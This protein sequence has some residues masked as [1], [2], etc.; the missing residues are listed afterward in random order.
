MLL[1]EQEQ[2]EFARVLE[3]QAMQDGT[4]WLIEGI[5]ETL[6]GKEVVKALMERR[7]VYSI[8]KN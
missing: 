3:F 4:I 6:D 2:E 7:N 8:P 1:S 5:G